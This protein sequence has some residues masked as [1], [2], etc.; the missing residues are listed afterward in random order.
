MNEAMCILRTAIAQHQ[1][2]AN[3]VI[4]TMPQQASAH[5]EAARELKS[6]IRTL[7]AFGY[8]E[9]VDVFSLTE[10]EREELCIQWKAFLWW[11]MPKLVVDALA[12]AI[13]K[14]LNVARDDVVDVVND[15]ISREANA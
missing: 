5:I 1:A 11:Y 14:Q 7:E 9:S 6:A 8:L 12:D 10:A 2:R 13:S 15:W 4:V 3:N